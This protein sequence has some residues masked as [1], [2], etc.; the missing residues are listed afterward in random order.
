MSFREILAKT[1][2]FGLVSVA[3]I[4]GGFLV[5]YGPHPSNDVSLF[6]SIFDSTFLAIGFW[7]AG[8]GVAGFG[9]LTVLVELRESK[10]EKREEAVHITPR[11][12]PFG[13]PPPWGMG[14][15]GR[16][17]GAV[18]EVGGRARGGGGPKLM[19]VATSTLDAPLIIG[20][21]FVVT[22]VAL[23]LKAH[24]GGLDAVGP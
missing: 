1:W 12:G 10:V 5:E 8:L 21:L 4:G 9:A 6:F 16:V 11:P 24:F 13:P 23:V 18:K 7:L 3:I 19:S 15:I 14:D 2:V 17:G 20:L 22:I